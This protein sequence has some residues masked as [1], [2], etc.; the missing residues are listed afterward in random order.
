M[1]L[2]GPWRDAATAPQEP[3]DNMG[4]SEDGEGSGGVADLVPRATEPG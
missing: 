3:P 4:G 1:Y 2:G